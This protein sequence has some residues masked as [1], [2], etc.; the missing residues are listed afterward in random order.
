MKS[1][2]SIFDI[3]QI[4]AWKLMIFEVFGWYGIFLGHSI[5]ID[6]NNTFQFKF[7]SILNCWSHGF[8]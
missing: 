6:E 3:F 7:L 5:G 1:Q 2:F 8:A 4:S